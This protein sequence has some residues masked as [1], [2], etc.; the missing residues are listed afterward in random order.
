MARLL[1]KG[2][3]VK[4]LAL[5][6]LLA[7]SGCL[8]LGR[9]N[10][11]PA[12]RL[13]SWVSE[14]NP[15]Q[16]SVRAIVSDDQ[17][18]PDELFKYL[19]FTVDSAE[20]DR[21]IH[22]C[23]YTLNQTPGSPLATVIFHRAGT[24]SIT[25]ET[26][27]RYQSPSTSD[28]IMITVKDEA[29]RFDSGA[30]IKP[31]T[32]RN[33]CNFYTADK[34]ITLSLD[35]AA[36]DDNFGV[37]CDA[38]QMLTYT[39]RIAGMPPNSVLTAWDG[40]SCAP[41]TSSSRSWLEVAT[42]TTQVCLWTDPTISDLS[43]YSVVV[44]VSDHVNPE[45]SGPT[46]DLPV[47]PDGPPC[48]TDTDPPAGRY[49]V[50]RSQ[51]QTFTAT[52]IDDR[53]S[54]GGGLTFVWQVSPDGGTTW[55]TVPDWALSTY[56]LDVSSLGLGQEVDVRVEAFDSTGCSVDAQNCAPKSCLFPDPAACVKR[57][58]WALELR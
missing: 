6:S 39:W 37:G 43:M 52:A 38:P 54:Y 31:T 2:R 19:Y 53:D 41:R 1:L 7:A 42:P 24:F 47:M 18:R 49:V 17:D 50:D 22:G 10:E 20:P 21:M 58:T 48:I 45:V 28:H 8:Y 40:S 57:K 11:P 3:P 4:G 44:G 55:S 29:P 14:T 27:D 32:A 46:V 5:A 12:I 25:A 51:I 30:T 34:A 9:L 26:V 33:F 23:D 13:T 16:V 56:Q 35:H 36:T 15:N